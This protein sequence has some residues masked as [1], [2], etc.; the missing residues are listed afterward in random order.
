MAAGTPNR[1]ITF[2]TENFP[3]S[4]NLNRF[5]SKCTPAVE[6]IAIGSGKNKAKT[7]IRTVP[8]PKPENRVSAEIINAEMQITRYSIESP[9]VLF[10]QSCF[11]YS[12]H[13]LTAEKNSDFLTK[14]KKDAYQLIALL[15]SSQAKNLK[16][17]I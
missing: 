16:I 10:C 15:L 17:R 9:F 8:K 13:S 1:I 14:T 3:T 7:G 2:H 6:A 4:V 12:R 11:I 5:V